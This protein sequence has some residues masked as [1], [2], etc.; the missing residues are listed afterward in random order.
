MKKTISSLKDALIVKQELDKLPKGDNYDFRARDVYE[1]AKNPNSPLHAYFE[2]D[3]D[4]CLDAYGLD[5]AGR[6]VRETKTILSYKRFD[7]N[8]NKVINQEMSEEEVEE[9]FKKRTNKIKAI[10]P[11]VVH[12]RSL[13]EG[14][15]KGETVEDNEKYQ[16]LYAQQA[17]QEL[18]AWADKYER[19]GELK[20]AVD[21][22]KKY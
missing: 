8:T 12:I 9:L 18:K 21:F 2:W 16:K 4:K 6:L 13:G 11:D 17:I 5:Q 7:L 22:I 10:Y 14:Y 3:V 1:S 19:I 20:E 15:L